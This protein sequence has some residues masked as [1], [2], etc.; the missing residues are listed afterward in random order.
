MRLMLRWT[1]GR[2][3]HSVMREAKFAKYPRSRVVP[4]EERAARGRCTVCGTR[5]LCVIQAQGEDYGSAEALRAVTTLRA[6]GRV[7]L[8]DR[9]KR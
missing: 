4:L 7:G 8:V 5:G 9:G 1:C 3:G 6:A 2:C